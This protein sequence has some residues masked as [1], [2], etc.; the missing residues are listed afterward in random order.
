MAAPHSAATAASIV[1]GRR[2]RFMR[3][4]FFLSAVVRRLA[5]LTALCLCAADG[6]IW[7]FTL[8]PLLCLGSFNLV[9]FLI[10]QFICSRPAVTSRCMMLIKRNPRN[11]ESGVLI[12]NLTLGLT[13]SHDST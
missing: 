11:D 4:L 7:H 10:S 13:F 12:Y 3:L 2:W 5:A 1:V 6:K 8:V 9:F